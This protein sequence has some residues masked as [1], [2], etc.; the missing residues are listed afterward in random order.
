MPNWTK[1]M[2][3]KSN[4]ISF[5]TSCTAEFIFPTTK[6]LCSNEYD[7]EYGNTY[8]HIYICMYIYIYIYIY[9]YAIMKTMCTPGYHHNGFLATH[10]LG[11]MMTTYIYIYVYI[12]YIYLFLYYIYLFYLSIY[13]SRS[14]VCT[15]IWQF[16]C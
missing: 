2:Y 6:S 3:F 12:F 15:R 8:I 10:A 14:K 16:I 4:N 13:L 1:D 11:H 9:I 5:F 7:N